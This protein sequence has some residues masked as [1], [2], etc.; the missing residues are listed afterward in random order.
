M[1][2]LLSD[3][4]DP[5]ANTVTVPADPSPPAPP[6]WPTLDAGLAAALHGLEPDLQRLAAGNHHDPHSVLGVHRLPDGR[7][8]MLAHVPQCVHLELEDRLAATRLPDTDFFAWTG[9]A[10]V[11]PPR[12][13]LVW[14][15]DRGQR[16]GVPLE[17]RH[18]ASVN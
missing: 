7:V 13:R 2:K 1:A 12:Y 16:I 18:G 11:L 5:P 14:Y 17:R 8:R 4:L 15:D 9:A 6:R 10:G 3:P